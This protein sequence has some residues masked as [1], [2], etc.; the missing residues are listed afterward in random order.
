[1]GKKYTTEDFISKAITVHGN[2]YDYSKVNYI[3]A[4]TKVIIICKKHGEFLQTPHNHITNK[5]G[6]PN[7]CKNH[8]R[9]TTETFIE[10]ANELHNGK[11][12]YSLVKYVDGETKVKI[13]CPIHGVFEQKPQ[14]HLNGQGCKKCGKL[15]AA[16]KM[17]KQKE[18]FIKQASL[19]HSYKYDYSLVEYKNAN[20]KVKIICPKH[21]EFWQTPHHHLKKHGCPKCNSSLLEVEMMEFL[22]KHEIKFIFQY[23]AKW[24]G[25]QSL[26]FF[27]PE[28]NAAI[29]CQGEQHF[30][31]VFYRSKHWT[32]EKAEKNFKEIQSKDKLKFKK[33][34]DNNVRLFYFSNEDFKD[35]LGVYTDK[36]KL[37]NDITKF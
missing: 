9:Y 29:E 16:K 22:N 14:K 31:E 23:R 1:M 2:K 11:Y 25:K 7:C 15:L 18:D 27:L 10:S 35:V 8:K 30:K 20:C 28:Y 26:D 34:L 19:I 17:S 5:A 4:N 24:L 3:N 33:C 12:D 6:C 13:I 21:G 36:N 32:K 37:I